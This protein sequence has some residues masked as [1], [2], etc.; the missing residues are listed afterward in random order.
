[1]KAADLMTTNVVTVAEDATRIPV[2]RIFDAD[3]RTTLLK[4]E[5]P[6]TSNGLGGDSINSI[7]IHPT[8]DVLLTASAIRGIELWNVADGARLNNGL[9]NGSTAYFAEAGE[10]VICIQRFEDKVDV[11]ETKTGELLRSLYIEDR[12]SSD[13]I[14]ADGRRLATVG[15][16][17]SVRV[18]DLATLDMISVLRGH[19]GQILG[20]DI[21]IDG[22][23]IATGG[24][25]TTARVW[26]AESRSQRFQIGMPTT[27]RGPIVD[28][29]ADNKQLLAVSRPRDQIAIWKVGDQAQSA[30]LLGVS[31][32]HAVSESI[33]LTAVSGRVDAWNPTNGEKVGA[34][35]LPGITSTSK[36][37]KRLA[38]SQTSGWAAV[39]LSD[40]RIILWNPASNQRRFLQPI[41]SQITI[42]VMSTDGKLVVAASDDGA[43]RIWSTVDSELVHES[44][45]PEKIV[46]LCINE[47]DSRLAGVTNL[48]TAYVWDLTTY[49]QLAK[50][51]K[52]GERFD[53]ARFS[54]QGD[55]LITLASDEGDVAVWDPQ[56]G[57]FL[58]E[59][60]EL[61]GVSRYAHHPD[62]D[63]WIAI[64]AQG[65]EKGEGAGARLWN[66]VTGETRRLSERPVHSI[67]IGK[68]KVIAIV[69]GPAADDD[70]A[71]STVISPN[72]EPFNYTADHP[73]PLD[74]K[75]DLISWNVAGEQLSSQ[76]VDL[77]AFRVYYLGSSNLALVQSQQHGFT[78]YSR[79]ANEPQYAAFGHSGRISDVISTS[80][81]VITAGYDGALVVWD[82]VNG[83]RSA[84]MRHLVPILDIDANQEQP[85][86]VATA[87][88]DGSVHIWNILD[89]SS[90]E[91][92][93]KG[94]GQAWFVKFDKSGK[95]LLS[96]HRDG[97]VI[98]TQLKTDGPNEQ[99]TW[100][101]ERHA[102][103]RADFSPDGNKL[104]MLEGEQYEPS[105]LQPR[106]FVGADNE[107][108]Y[109]VRIY[110]IE[111]MSDA[112]LA[113][114]PHQSAVRFAHF[115]AKGQY[116]IT[117]Q[118]SGE[119][120]LWQVNP[121]Q[122]VRRI[123]EAVQRD[124]YGRFT[125]RLENI[126]AEFS[127][128]SQFIYAE[129][130]DY[131]GVADYALLFRTE[132][133]QAIGE[134]RREARFDPVESRRART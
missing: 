63:E 119:I 55:Y 4:K 126:Y 80:S 46:D 109:V 96:V 124:H 8:Q 133:G 26:N 120:T 64:C 99:K 82:R 101:S 86:Q 89:G 62:E 32:I 103:N 94:H 70:A 107:K 25:D 91:I 18:W 47:S 66:Y 12:L 58:R 41:K 74:G 81:N 1:M 11:R 37:A 130:S 123:G 35:K 102:L 93:P 59:F 131:S 73:M 84:Q 128:D 5:F 83:N 90:I 40:G 3:S 116:V 6:T 24:H 48:N 38:F 57:S 14:S 112:P 16:D 33:C 85:S 31:S 134:A 104:L 72:A 34:L 76:D 51:A 108:Q 39:G 106:P 50:V 7:Q 111:P 78:A 28:A 98:L 114:L 117:A 36:A 68:Q 67:A 92:V 19:T 53:E 42:M 49:Q 23:R 15:G 75:Y 22:A 43:V 17:T 88:A 27:G 105:G 13:A 65:N 60:D 122:K 127:P 79:E 113:E 52:N 118:T 29:T 30:A 97:M 2:V 61:M 132:D 100:S 54:R 71:R 20:L 10:K 9:W 87:I 125:P 56:T 115:D 121:A 21:S 77:D 129:F 69:R 95:K 110:T 44:T 45:Q